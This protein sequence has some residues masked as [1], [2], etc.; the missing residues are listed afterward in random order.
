[1]AFHLF[2]AGRVSGG[3]DI[4]LAI[5]GFLFTAMLLREAAES[6]GTIR[7]GRYLLRLLRRLVI[8]AGLVIAVTFFASWL[9]FPSTRNAQLLV[10][11]RASLLYFENWQLI[12]DSMS[13]EVA[14]ATASPFQHFWSLSVQG[15]FFL[16]W[17]LVA[18]AA[19]WC[20]KRLN[21]SAASVMT[22]FVMLVLAVSFTHA[23]YMQTINQ[24]RAYLM[25]TTRFWEF[26]FGGLLALLASR[27]ALGRAARTVSGWVGLTLVVSTGFIMDGAEVFPG[28]LALWPLIG[29]ALILMSSSHPNPTASGRS[30]VDRLLTLKP[31]NWV[32]NLAYGLYLWHWP[33][34]IFYLEIRDREQVGL[35]GGTLI[36]ALSFALAWLT[37]RLVEV[38]LSRSSFSRPRLKLGLA[39][40]VL[41]AAAVGSSATLATLNEPAVAG[42]PPSTAEGT[43]FGAAAV[44]TPSADP[45]D[46]AEIHPPIPAI[47][48]DMPAYYG[49]DCRQ[50]GGNDP[51][52]GEA[53]VC[54]DPDAPESPKATVML[55]GGSHAGQWHAA[56]VLMA[57][58][59]DWELI[60]ADKSGCR[61]G[62]VTDVSAN[63]C[64]EWNVDFFDV[65]RE[66]QPDLVVTPGSVVSREGGGPEK[67]E[68]GAP[69]R[70]LEIVETGSDLLLMRGTPRPN[71]DVPECLAGGRGALECGPTF[72]TLA[73]KNP[74]NGIDL[75]ESTVSVDMTEYICWEDA[76]PAVIGDVAVY[77][78]DSHLTNSYVESMVP[79]LEEQLKDRFPFLFKR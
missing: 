72:D 35:R 41:A 54:E 9:V 33:L 56:F 42:T 14:D 64:H 22:V 65:L 68:A 46:G 8:P 73:E 77:R 26:A 55:A 79:M 44:G 31:I 43:P 78:D 39:A 1:M 6:G 27:I 66:R 19:V 11:V 24:D 53:L 59:N 21:R 75:P 49:W 58:E 37:H 18:V 28:P 13:Y 48:N 74:L 52:T 69:D 50:R 61:F 15:Q 20:A 23:I 57:Q 29:F 36:L 12:A 25:T 4:F 62:E 71:D 38:P 5:S 30:S 76:C 63:M 16:I 60:L 34:L 3:I 17:P 45:W 7:V 47:R 67:I 10:E 40:G 2:G 70:W 51:G 32:G